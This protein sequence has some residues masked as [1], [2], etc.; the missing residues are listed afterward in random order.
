M[1]GKKI[2]EQINENKNTPNDLP[3]PLSPSEQK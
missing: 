2:F 3:K 1:D